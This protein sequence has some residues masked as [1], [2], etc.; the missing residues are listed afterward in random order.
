M[1]KR[2]KRALIFAVS[3]VVLA[4]VCGIS[5]LLISFFE[6]K[7]EKKPTNMY[8]DEL[9]SY[10]FYEPD[11]D[12][13]VTTVD[14]YME[15]DRLLYYKNGAEEYGIDGDAEKY[16]ADI[17]FFQKY[18]EIVIEGRWEE[19]N[20]LFTDHYYETNEKKNR[21]APQMIYD[22]H[23]EKLWEKDETEDRLAFNVSYRIYKNNGTFR[24]D[25]DS[26]ASKVLYFELVIENGEYKIDRITY[27][28]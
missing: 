25:I 21:F 19:Y 15:L 2:K 11:Y 20:E 13:D 10:I 1:D 3:S 22:M 8:S 16:G 17:V 7:E 23:I 27:Y 5:L 6:G 4:I 24:N 18:F 14:E 26:G 28:I 9:H 12:L